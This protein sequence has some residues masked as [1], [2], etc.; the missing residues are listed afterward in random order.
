MLHHLSTVS[1]RVAFAHPTRVY[2]GGSILS[3]KIL[4]QWA[5]SK[6]RL[7]PLSSSA[8]FSSDSSASTS[9]SSPSVK[10]KELRKVKKSEDY[11]KLKDLLGKFKAHKNK[12]G[13]TGGGGK[14]SK[15][16]NNKD[17]ERS[18]R[19]FKTPEGSFF[20]YR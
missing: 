4:F 10:G 13:N 18:I 9:T 6:Q 20:H 8:L 19:S 2:G 14:N 3:E 16:R 15:K 7:V 11:R 1:P 12:D 5:H 17:N